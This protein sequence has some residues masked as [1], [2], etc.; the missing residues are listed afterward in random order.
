MDINV[1]EPHA[2]TQFVD[3]NQALTELLSADIKRLALEF[4]TLF[5]GDRFDD[6][7]L[8]SL[9]EI[10]LDEVKIYYIQSALA[11]TASPSFLTPSHFPSLGNLGIRQFY[12]HKALEGL[13]YER[14][15]LNMDSMSQ[16]DCMALDEKEYLDW[17]DMPDPFSPPP[18]FPVP[19]LFDLE[20]FHDE[21]QGLHA[22]LVPEYAREQ[23]HVRLRLRSEPP[24]PDRTIRITLGLAI[25]LLDRSKVLKELYLDHYSPNRKGKVY[26]QDARLEETRRKFIELGREKKVE[27]ISED[28][29]GSWCGGRASKEFWRRCREKRGK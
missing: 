17:T 18:S 10:S 13:T 11:T 22:T 7:A 20:L 14:V 3:P 6:F 4:A 2:R 27:I 29:E 5:P 12:Y 26:E 15:Y 23:T 16:L 24:P 25:D 1:R 28:H 19:V 21:Y 9:E 8:S